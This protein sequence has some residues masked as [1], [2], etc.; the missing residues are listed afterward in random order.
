[1]SERIEYEVGAKVDESSFEAVR[2][3][4]DDLGQLLAS[5][6]SPSGEGEASVFSAMTGAALGAA[7]AIDGALGRSLG[8]LRGELGD[9]LTG[10]RGLGD[11][12]GSLGSI[13]AG[14]LLELLTRFGATRASMAAVNQLWGQTEASASLARAGALNAALQPAALA[15]SIASFGSAAATGTAAY[16]ASLGAASLTSLASQSIQ[17]LLSDG[18]GF[19]SGGYTGT[20]GK[21]EPAGIVHRGEFVFPRESVSAAGGPG[22][23]YALLDSLGGSSGRAARTEGLSSIPAPAREVMPGPAVEGSGGRS[24][25]HVHFSESALR[26][27]IRRELDGEVYVADAYTGRVRRAR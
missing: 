9:V 15:A 24:S 14:S 12:L 17:G 13:A 4:F 21:F 11:L 3:R 20:G 5:G 2:K 23:F 19:A 18:S 1:M 22:Y 25:V 26:E 16:L 27:A 6:G 8:R 7:D 10:A